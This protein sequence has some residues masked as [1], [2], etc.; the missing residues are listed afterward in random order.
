VKQYRRPEV[1]PV[2]RTPKLRYPDVHRGTTGKAQG[3]QH[4][5]GGYLAYVTGTAK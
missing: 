5:T 2:C 3:C 4:R 1:E